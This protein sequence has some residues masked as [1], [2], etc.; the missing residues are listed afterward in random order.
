MDANRVQK[1][2]EQNLGKNIVIKGEQFTCRRR[3]RPYAIASVLKL[4]RLVLST[5]TSSFTVVVDDNCSR[6]ICLFS[7]YQRRSTILVIVGLSLLGFGVRV[8]GGGRWG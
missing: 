3:T 8:W 6:G 2:R 4:N 5:T 7:S 1:G